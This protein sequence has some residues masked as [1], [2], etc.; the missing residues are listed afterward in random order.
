VNEIF[1]HLKDYTEKHFST[2]EK[3]LI[4]FAYKDF[5]QHKK[6]HA[7]FITKLNDLYK[8]FEKGKVTISIEILNFLK[9]W[10]LNHILISDFK[11]ASCILNQDY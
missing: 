2:E 11:Y 10:L 9:D 3:M 8:D 1:T 6:E 7:K 4:K 5:E